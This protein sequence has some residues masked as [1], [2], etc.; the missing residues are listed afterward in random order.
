VGGF[1]EHVRAVAGSKASQRG[2][3]HAAV[4][5]TMM[6]S[7]YLVMR[8]WSSCALLTPGGSKTGC[9][10]ERKMQRAGFV[11]D[12]WSSGPPIGESA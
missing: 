10:L 11:A 12:G 3:K 2:G 1:S 8:S 6:L 9:W 7:I 4:M 5:P